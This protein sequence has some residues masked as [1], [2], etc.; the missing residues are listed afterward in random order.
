MAKNAPA[1]IL[2]EIRKL[3]IVAGQNEEFG[4]ID[5]N[6]I[7]CTYGDCCIRKHPDGWEYGKNGKRHGSAV[8][9]YLDR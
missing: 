9:A 8:D 3:Q 5:E 6:T 4:V 2:L 1:D 7:S